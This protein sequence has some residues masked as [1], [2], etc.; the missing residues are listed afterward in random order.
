MGGYSFDSPSP[1]KKSKG[2]Q[3]EEMTGRYMN[4]VEPLDDSSSA[5]SAPSKDPSPGAMV[6]V[7]EVVSL[8][9]GNWAHWGNGGNGQTAETGHTG[10]TGE[11]GE[12]GKNWGTGKLG[13]LGKLGRLGKLGKLEKLG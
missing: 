13:K 8:S 1:R 3:E 10:E 9:W 2:S 6:G 11:T 4:K 12:N 7:F 5:D